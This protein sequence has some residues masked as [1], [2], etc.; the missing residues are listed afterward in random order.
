MLFKKKKEEKSKHLVGGTEKGGTYGKLPNLD[1]VHPHDFVVL[2]RTKTQ[3]RDE[4]DEEEDDAAAEEGVGQAGDG[5]GELVTE[6]DV[7]FVEPAAVDFGGA[8]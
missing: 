3:S 7:V 4:V 5:V 8:V 1:I 2:G 6:L